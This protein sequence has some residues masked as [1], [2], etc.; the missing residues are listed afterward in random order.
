MADD[1]VPKS[2]LIAL[3]E[4]Q[5][6]AL[7]ELGTKH[8]EAITS[9]GEEHTGIID[10]LNTQIR[11]GTEELGRSRATI[12]ELEEKG[13]T[14][15]TTATEL[16]T[17]KKELKSAQD[18]LK[19]SQETLATDL[20]GTLITNFKVAEKALEGKTVTELISIRDVLAKSASPNS[21]NYVA[22]GGGGGSDKKTTG[23]Q[24]ITEGLEAGELKAT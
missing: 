21:N 20:K 13:K 12:T 18:S 6:K 16:E 24:K 22:G 3:K 19:A 2:D 1:M 10:G 17:S 11:T 8:T 5:T 4:S 23:K 15:E 14:H 7:G 9:L